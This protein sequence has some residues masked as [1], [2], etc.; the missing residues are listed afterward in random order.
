[1]Q[2]SQGFSKNLAF[3]FLVL[4]L[5]GPVRRLAAAN[6]N[7]FLSFSALDSNNNV[8]LPGR[9]YVPPAYAT[10]PNIQRPLI[11]YLH[12]SG[13]SGT[14]NVDH[15][16]QT[17]LNNMVV[18]AR[19]FGFF[20]YAPQ[21]NSGWRGST[22]LS[23]AMTMIDRAILERRVDTNR[24]YVTGLSMGGGGVW[25]FLSEFPNRFAAA[26]PI[27]AV[28][29]SVGFQPANVFEEPIWAFHARDD[30]I[31]PPTES[32]EVIDLLLSEAHQ[33]LPSYPPLTD[34]NA[35]FFFNDSLLDL[36]YTEFR[37]GGHIIWS[38]VYETKAVY[39]WMLAHGATVPEPANVVMLTFALMSG[40]LQRRRTS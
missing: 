29:P 17:D 1:M 26:V 24:I 38:Q 18:A 32:R 15:I 8:L 2:A 39:D 3:L 9:L 14:D 5:L 36:R 16:I 28:S 37:S 27:C 11:L 25:N 20:I 23:S 40:C 35:N 22:V 6:I 33:P 7:D 12:G 4:A 19:R 30:G 10:D 34:F 21:T 13:Q 31:V